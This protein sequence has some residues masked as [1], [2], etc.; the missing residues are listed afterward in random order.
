[1]STLEN[2][3]ATISDGVKVVAD[4]TRKVS[5]L[6]GLKAQKTSAQSALS[7][8]YRILGEQYYKDHADENIAY[9]EIK[10]EIKK[11]QEKISDINDKIADARGDV[12]CDACG[13][14]VD[15]DCDYCP[16]CGAKIETKAVDTEE[17]GD[18]VSLKEKI[19]AA[20]DKIKEVVKDAEI[21][22]KLEAAGTKVGNKVKEIANDPELKGKI[23]AAGDK[24]KEVAK[25]VGG[26]VSDAIGDAK[27]YLNSRKNPSDIVNAED[28]ENEPSVN[29][30]DVEA[31]K[32]EAAEAEN[33]AE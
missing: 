16:K 13:A 7:K 4:K 29:A 19:G 32:E 17:K 11:L 14:Y 6:A 27:D 5:G 23:S 2:L 22:E 20:G 26:K 1:M 3:G 28:V 8:Q 33:K 15:K 31:P 10:E 24:A 21:K 9:G 18:D 30:E 12:K 25:E